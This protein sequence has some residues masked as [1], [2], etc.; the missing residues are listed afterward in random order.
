MKRNIILLAI[1]L[2]SSIV[3]WMTYS[4]GLSGKFSQI[5]KNKR[6]IA[7]D[8]EKYLNHKIIRDAK[9]PV[10]DGMLAKNIDDKK[11]N[12]PSYFGQD[13]FNHVNTI[14]QDLGIRNESPSLPQDREIKAMSG[15]EYIEFELAIRCSFEKFGKFVNELEKSDK[16]FIINR[17]E[18]SNSITHG[19]QKALSTNGKYPDKEIT[20]RIWAVNL[21]KG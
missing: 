10:S 13:V 14:L 21:S 5:N 3:L 18:F 4:F 15:F 9:H 11:K 12:D 16:I 19:V 2:C 7:K 8:Y 17:F 20:M 6:N 1:A